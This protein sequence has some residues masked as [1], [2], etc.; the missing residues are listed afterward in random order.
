MS[1]RTSG[2]HR[3]SDGRLRV[4][5]NSETDEHR[6]GQRRVVGEQVVL[7]G[8]EPVH[9]DGAGALGDDLVENAPTQGLVLDQF[10]VAGS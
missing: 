6:T 1:F 7:T 8:D 2:H 3:R 4:R 9:P 10:G 5:C